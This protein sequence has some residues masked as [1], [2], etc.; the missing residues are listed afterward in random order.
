MT[1][2]YVLYIADVMCSDAAD[3][4]RIVYPG[5]C[6]KYYECSG[7]G[8]VLRTCDGTFFDEDRQEECQVP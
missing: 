3:G 6:T 4:T 7:G 1:T 5:D 2:E 8:C